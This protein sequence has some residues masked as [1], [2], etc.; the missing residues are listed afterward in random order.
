MSSCAGLIFGWYW[1]NIGMTVVQESYLSK[2]KWCFL[3][4]GT[5]RGQ[6]Y[7]N[8]LFWDARDFDWLEK[9]YFDVQTKERIRS[10]QALPRHSH[11]KVIPVCH[12]DGI[13]KNSTEVFLKGWS[14][15][16]QQS[17][18]WDPLEICWWRFNSITP[19]SVF[20]CLTFHH[21]TVLCP[22]ELQSECKCVM[23]YH[24]AVCVAVSFLQVI[25][26]RP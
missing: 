5:Y 18:N 2:S 19:T 26:I 17:K 4:E 25:H 24:F 11:F 20:F 12:Y 6:D 7:H 10:R 23:N 16:I 3:I 22:G 8:T 14:H 1:Y 15:K 21:R 9:T 13:K